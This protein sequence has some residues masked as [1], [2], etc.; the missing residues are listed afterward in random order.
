MTLTR[1]CI[2]CD[3]SNGLSESDIIPDALTNSRIY[4]KNV[5]RI[6]H[7]NNF[8]DLFESE[9][10]K[11]LAFIT[12]ELDI[13]SSKGDDYHFYKATLTIGDI[14][15]NAKKFKSNNQLFKKGSVLESVDKKHKLGHIDVLKNIVKDESKITTIDINSIQIEK[16]VKVDTSIFLSESMYRLVSKIAYEWYCAKNKIIGKNSNFDNIISYITMGEGENPVTIISDPSIYYSFNQICT[17]GSHCLFAYL[18]NN[19]IYV[20]VNLFGIALYNVKIANSPIGN[21]RNCLYQE[22][23]TDGSRVEIYEDSVQSLLKNVESY[24]DSCVKTEHNGLF[25]MVAPPDLADS[26]III[27]LS[28]VQIYGE[29][30]KINNVQKTTNG[31]IDLIL[32]NIE[33]LLQATSIHKKTL[34]RFVEENFKNN[35]I[36][37]ELNPQNQNN[38]NTFLFYVIYLIG[39]SEND[40]LDQNIVNSII[41]TGLNIYDSEFVLKNE[42]CEKLRD[43][44]L[45]DSNYQKVIINGARLVREWE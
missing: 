27:K 15:Y 12:N 14:K 44:I 20:V 9:V 4:N 6:A 8:S 24:L 34:K 21:F 16:S 29:L 19:S 32:K 38:K 1:K 41:K 28:L 10:I 40:T 33:S 42:T 7:N 26:N 43:V 36:T 11:K 45:Q 17:H 3:T 37:F 35:D 39:K 25:F 30:Q 22:L 2:Y 18:S 31:V 5:C 23:L 13:K